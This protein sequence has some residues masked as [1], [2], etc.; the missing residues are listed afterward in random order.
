MLC[1]AVLVQMIAL[2]AQW[3]YW[4]SVETFVYTEKNHGIFFVFLRKFSDFFLSQNGKKCEFTSVASEKKYDPSKSTRKIMTKWWLSPKSTRKKV[5]SSI[6]LCTRHTILNI[7]IVKIN[8]HVYCAF[9]IYIF[10]VIW[11]KYWH[12]NALFRTILWSWIEVFAKK[13]T[14]LNLFKK[15]IPLKSTLIKVCPV[16]NCPVN[17]V[18]PRL[19]NVVHSLTYGIW[20]WQKSIEYKG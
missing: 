5:R 2:I 1:D 19:L 7:F 8:M 14:P 3:K 18:F 15:N 9:M 11:W 4:Y 12:Q 16:K 13:Y 20:I 6:E 17:L 10:V